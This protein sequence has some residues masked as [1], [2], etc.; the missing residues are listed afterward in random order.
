MAVGLNYPSP[1]NDGSIWMEQ[2]RR[3]SMDVLDNVS[4][5]HCSHTSLRSVQAFETTE[6]RR[7]TTL[8]C[9]EDG[10]FSELRG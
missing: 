6:P 2:D 10:S 9:I 4:K 7:L 1:M 8:V 5:D 3:I